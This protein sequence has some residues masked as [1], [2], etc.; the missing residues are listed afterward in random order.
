MRL[1]TV[2]LTV[3]TFLLATVAAVLTGPGAALA[4]YTWSN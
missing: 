2:I 4:G 3:V 1:R